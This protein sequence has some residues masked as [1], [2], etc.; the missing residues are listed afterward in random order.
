MAN[1]NWDSQELES[2]AAQVNT[3]L[4]NYDKTMDE[5]QQTLN[6]ME[7]RLKLRTDVDND[8]SKLKRRVSQ[9]RS[10]MQQ[11][12]QTVNL[13][14]SRTTDLNGKLI[15]YTNDIGDL[16]IK[17]NTT[18][19]SAGNSVNFLQWTALGSLGVSGMVDV[20]SGFVSKIGSWFSGKKSEQTGTSTTPSIDYSGKE[21]PNTVSSSDVSNT[22][23]NASST[24][25]KTYGLTES[26]GSSRGNAE[27]AGL[28]YYAQMDASTWSVNGSGG[29][30]YLNK[31]GAVGCGASAMAMVAS[32]YY[33]DRQDYNPGKI[34]DSNRAHTVG[35]SQENARSI[36]LRISNLGAGKGDQDTQLTAASQQV[37]ISKLDKALSDYQSG[38]G[39]PPV[40][41]IDN[42][43]VGNNHYVVILGKNSDGSYIIAD[44]NQRTGKFNGCTKL[45]TTLDAGKLSRKN[46]TYTSYIKQIYLFDKL[47]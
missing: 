8:L 16:S 22:T 45:V 43:K 5:I 20:I 36:G 4:Q 3:L 21:H 44:S 25:Q 1:I 30:A 23:S 10:K 19:I 18:N 11:V 9:E 24:T 38:N 39:A 28:R 27:A 12:R 42:G 14:A 33:P 2:T 35:I 13:A 31:R 7:F 47:E 46:G 41:G 29:Q 34:A 6:T 32:Y 40:V 37:M 15:G 26:T 17:S